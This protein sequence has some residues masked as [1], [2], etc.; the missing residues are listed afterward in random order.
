[1]DRQVITNGGAEAAI[2]DSAVE[3]FGARLHG[4]LLRPAD[5]GYE[6]GRRVWNGKQRCDDWRHEHAGAARDARRFESEDHHGRNQHGD[7]GHRP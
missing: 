7:L 3:A 6:E 4:E 5:A 1:M 2:G